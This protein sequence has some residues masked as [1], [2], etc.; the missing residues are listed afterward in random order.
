MQYSCV[1][2]INPLQVLAAPRKY[3]NSPVKS[4]YLCASPVF[5]R[6]CGKIETFAT[7]HRPEKSNYLLASTKLRIAS[8][9][10]SIAILDNPGTWKLAFLGFGKRQYFPN[11]SEAAFLGLLRKA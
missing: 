9:K 4:F 3:R 10:L 1:N 6:P 8:T 2:E 11:P 5:F 7:A